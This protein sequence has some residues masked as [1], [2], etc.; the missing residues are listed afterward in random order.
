LKKEV[1]KKAD[2]LEFV[3]KEV[4]EMKKLW[5]DKEFQTKTQYEAQLQSKQTEVVKLSDSLKTVTQQLDQT[6]KE[7]TN[8]TLEATNLRSENDK[9][10]KKVRDTEEEMRTLLSELERKKFV[11]VQLGKML[12]S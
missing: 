8:L 12:S 3:E 4:N 7:H 9:M 10:K 6:T 11:A 5:D 1:K 2:M